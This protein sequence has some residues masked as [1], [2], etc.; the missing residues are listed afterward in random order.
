MKGRTVTRTKAYQ[1]IVTLR[2]AAHH[3][4][5]D[6]AALDVI[7]EAQYQCYMRLGFEVRKFNEWERER[8]NSLC[9]NARN[10]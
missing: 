10:Y 2:N 1:A 9:P 6:P 4:V 8:R 3:V 5:D 7:I